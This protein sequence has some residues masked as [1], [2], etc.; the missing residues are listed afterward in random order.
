MK[1]TLI[2]GLLTLSALSFAATN[3][4]T[5]SNNNM[6]ANG[7][8]MNGNTMQHGTTMNGQGSMMTPEMIKTMEEK[9]M[10]KDGKCVMMNNADSKTVTPEKK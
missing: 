3:Q 9:G 10:M 1:K 8:M 5:T 2:L 4:N 7:T 6:P